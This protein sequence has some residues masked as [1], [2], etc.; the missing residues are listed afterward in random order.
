[1][2]HG[3]ALLLLQF[4]TLCVQVLVTGLSFLFVAGMG[5]LLKERKDL[6]HSGLFLALTV[7][8]VTL[9]EPAA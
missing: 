4:D 5:C 9:T 7:S 1:M 3:K 8:L 2:V 6:E